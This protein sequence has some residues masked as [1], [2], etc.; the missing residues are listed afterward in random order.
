M[1]KFIAASKHRRSVRGFTLLELMISIAIFSLMSIAAYRLF[2]SV[3]H[4]Q[5]STQAVWEHMA[6]VQ[7]ALLVIDRDFA[8]V[9]LRPVR[10]DYG[11]KEP[12]FVAGKGEYLVEFTRGGWRNPL[13]LRRSELQRV[14]YWLDEDGRLMR[15]YWLM[16]DRTPDSEPVDQILFEN[17]SRLSLQVQDAEKNWHRVWPLGKSHRVEKTKENKESKEGKEENKS[18]ELHLPLAIAL[19]FEHKIYGDIEYVVPMVNV[20]DFAESAGDK[21][22]DQDE[23]EDEDDDEYY[24]DED[25]EYYDDEEDEE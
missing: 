20:K 9:V 18:Q 19:S 4:A 21:K 5:R 3:L 12:A 11:S 1:K 15:R 17:V 23:D 22:K 16:L 25:D 13:G 7:R 2:D 24:D 10:D 6:E 8:Q 14:A